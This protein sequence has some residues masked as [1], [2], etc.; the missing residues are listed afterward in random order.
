MLKRQYLSLDTTYL[1]FLSFMEKGCLPVRLWDKY[2]NSS[3]PTTPGIN[4]L[5]KIFTAFGTYVH[6]CVHVCMFKFLLKDWGH[7]RHYLSTG[8]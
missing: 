2:S 3:C 1:W 8:F 4:Y 6:K 5:L 7:N